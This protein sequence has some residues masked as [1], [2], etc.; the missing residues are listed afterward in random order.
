MKTGACSLARPVATPARAVEAPSRKVDKAPSF[1][2]TEAEDEARTGSE[3][4]NEDESQD[5][6]TMPETPN[7][8]PSRAQDR[9]RRKEPVT[10]AESMELCTTRRLGR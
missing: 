3:D 8:K 1:P 2:A 7:T 5:D 10:T 6:E 9:R 4:D